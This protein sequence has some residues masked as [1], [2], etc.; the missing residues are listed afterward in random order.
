MVICGLEQAIGHGIKSRRAGRRAMQNYFHHWSRQIC[1]AVLMLLATLLPSNASVFL[2]D[3]T[4]TELRDLIAAGSTTIIIPIGGTE[5]NGP[6]MALGKHNARVKFLAEKIATKLGNALVAP[7]ISYVPEGSIEPPT[8]HMKF[9]GTITISD[10][11]FE[12]M[13]ESASRSFKHHGFKTIVLIGD[14]GSYQKDESLVAAKL[15]K[16]WAK[17][18]VAVFASTEYYALS[19]SKFGDLL[20]EK[21]FKESEIGTH[22]GLLDTSLLLAIDP[23]MVRMDKITSGPK[24]GTADGVYGGDPTKS[25]AELGQLGIDLI[26]NGTTQAI[27]NFVSKQ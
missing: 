6:D 20:K 13:L 22:A 25:S 10:A 4:W 14:H 17:S 24:L 18:G 1:G 3:Q 11:V 9:P 16:E 27:Q 19:Q 2:E 7:V 8:A 21:G 23:N 26:V 15:N 12:A 5:Q